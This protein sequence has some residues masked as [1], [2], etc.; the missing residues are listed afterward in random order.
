MGFNS[1]CDDSANAGG[2]TMNT[3]TYGAITKALLL[4]TFQISSASSAFAGDWLRDEDG[5]P[6]LTLEQEAEGYLEPEK[7]AV[8]CVDHALF[9]KRYSPARTAPSSLVRFGDGTEMSV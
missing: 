9:F 1:S 2:N 3:P 7:I 6:I 4:A 8:G 5:F